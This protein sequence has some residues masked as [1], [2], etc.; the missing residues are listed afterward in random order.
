VGAFVSSAKRQRAMVA[1]P[2]ARVTRLLRTFVD[3]K[4]ALARAL[5]RGPHVPGLFSSLPDVVG[6]GSVPRQTF[7]EELPD[8][9]F[10]VVSDRPPRESEAAI[11]LDQ[12]RDTL[13]SERLP[14][15][16]AS[17]AASGLPPGRER[18]PAPVLAV[19]QSGYCLD[20]FL[21]HRG[22]VSFE[23]QTGTVRVQMTIQCSLV[24]IRYQ[25][26]FMR[27]MA[28]LDPRTRGNVLLDI[29]LLKRI[30]M[31][32]DVYH[33]RR[34]GIPGHF[35]EQFIM[36]LGFKQTMVAWASL[37]DTTEAATTTGALPDIW[38]PGYEGAP[39][40][41]QL[42]HRYGRARELDVLSALRRIGSTY[43]R[44]LD[45]DAEWSI[46]GLVSCRLN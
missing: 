28:S 42:I 2:V 13:P 12:L 31:A 39:S 30:L 14:T 5:R 40:M 38:H 27:Q 18:I 19:G 15:L 34:R 11:I 1:I 7:V 23:N 36:Q 22:Q 35:V 20:F 9:D 37:P 29:R 16:G 44:A 33:A 24:N 41:W 3:V 17:R 46:E 10:V 21:D 6:I 4:S 45:N 8:F 26:Y 25:Q 43:Q 32:A